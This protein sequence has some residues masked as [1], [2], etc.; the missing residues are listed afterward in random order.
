MP[1]EIKR[2]IISWSN[3]HITIFTGFSEETLF[4]SSLK[5]IKDEN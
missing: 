2:R 1:E 4:I 3:N 5:P